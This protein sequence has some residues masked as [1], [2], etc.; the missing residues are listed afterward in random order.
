MANQ[1][2]ITNITTAANGDDAFDVVS[3][4][5]TVVLVPDVADLRPRLLRC[6]NFGAR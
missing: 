6:G 5:N 3:N 1:V 4:G 2:I